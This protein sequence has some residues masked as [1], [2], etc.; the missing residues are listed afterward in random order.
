MATFAGRRLADMVENTATVV[1]IEAMAAAQGM[2]FHRPLKSSA[3]VEGEFAEIRRRVSFLDGDRYMATDI[4]AMHQWATK[5][6]WLP[7]LQAVL[8]SFRS[9]LFH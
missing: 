2:E 6:N 9:D 7:T 8:P 1:G 3:I 4:E 5:T